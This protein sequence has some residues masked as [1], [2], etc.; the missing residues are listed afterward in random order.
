MVEGLANGLILQNNVAEETVLLG[1][2]ES[3]IQ[4]FEAQAA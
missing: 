3:E 4:E 1:L 2:S